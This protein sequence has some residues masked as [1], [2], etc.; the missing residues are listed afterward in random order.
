MAMFASRILGTLVFESSVFEEIEADRAATWQA[1]VVVIASSLATG[2]G[3]GGFYDRHLSTFVLTS[4]VALVTWVAWAMLTLQIG[5]RVLPGPETHADLGE[6]LRTLGF[7][8][9]P[10]LLQ[11]FAIFPYMLGPV[12]VVTTIWMFAAMVVA[13]RHA[14]DYRS[15]GRALAVCG[16]AVALSFGLAI[17]MAVLFGPAAQ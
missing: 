6:L 12:L 11:V 17:V 8:A 4:A 5:T 13:V 16:L 3:V 10:G 9:A 1:V 15:I 2:F 14:L 7:A